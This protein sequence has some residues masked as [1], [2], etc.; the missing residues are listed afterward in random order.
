M[1]NENISC[2]INQQEMSQPSEISVLQMRMRASKTANQGVLPPP[3]VIAEEL[4]ECKKQ[5]EQGNRI[6][7]RELRY[8]WNK[9]SEP[10]DLHLLYT[11][12]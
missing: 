10:E 11:E 9:F 7:P 6:G 1:W 2:Y 3:T 8:I 5:G 12:C 4:G